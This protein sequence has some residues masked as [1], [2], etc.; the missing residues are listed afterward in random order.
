LAW[1]LSL[2]TSTQ[3]AA[4]E[5]PI[6]LPTCLRL[7]GAQNLDIELA[8][9]RLKEAEANHTAA[10]EQFFPWLAPGVTYHRRDG[11]AQA[12]PAGTI[13]EAHFQSYS[14]GAA[15]GAQLDLGDA[16]YRRLA[17]KQLVKASSEQLEAE[18]Q[19]SILKAAIG[20]FELAKANALIGV[21]RQA[22][23]TSEDYRG[24][25]HRAVEVGIAFRGDELRVQTQTE[26]YQIALRQATEQ[27]RLAGADLAQVLHLDPTLDLRPQDGPLLPLTLF[28]TNSSMTNLVARALKDRPELKQS[29]ALV[30]AAR[31]SKNGAVYGPL[32]PTLGAQAFA[33][34]L[35]GGPDHG[36]STFGA[37]EDYFLGATWKIG[38]GG[39][40]DFGR[41]HANEARLATAQVGEA[42]LK[43]SIAGEVVTSLTRVQSW[44]DQI[45][46]AERNLQ[47]AT[48][49]L[50][51][52]RERKQYGV[53]V[54]LEDVQAQQDLARARSD[55][56]SAIAEY[57]KSQYGLSHA[58][59]SAPSPVAAN[60]QQPSSDT[61]MLGV[62]PSR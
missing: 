36:P 60:G 57:N 58:V 49:T 39:L 40:L 56:V 27:Q 44:S 3:A 21:A 26:R 31:A 35:G 14:P 13:S 62:Q 46:L 20:Y 48:E 29:Y 1:L 16:L 52:A 9:Q 59:G 8:R 4:E 37:E 25:I 6:D 10:L 55:Y 45:V 41:I 19:S 53:G 33:G 34:G 2:T 50:R 5:Y 47:S 42:K 30:S 7:A 15:L 51:L 43:D 28:A 23:E 17:A 12:V 24:Q 11:L 38:S 18:R 61:S 54:V 32:I 22:L